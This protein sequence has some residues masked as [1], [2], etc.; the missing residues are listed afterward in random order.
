M[1]SY[2]WYSAA[3][4]TDAGTKIDGATSASY[5]IK[6]V[7]E[8]KTY[9][10]VVTNTK[11]GVSKS[12][13]SG[14]ITITMTE[15]A[16]EV[17]AQ[18]PVIE[19]DL[20]EKQLLATGASCTLTVTATSSDSGTL[21]Y[22]WYSAENATD[23]GTAIADAT[24]ESYT[25]ASFDGTTCYYY[26][27]ITNTVGAKK[28]KKESRRTVVVLDGTITVTLDIETI[29]Y[30]EFSEGIKEVKFRDRTAENKKITVSRGTTLAEIIKENDC[31]PIIKGEYTEEDSSVIEY[32][33]CGTFYNKQF[34]TEYEFDEFLSEEE[35]ENA[36]E[37]LFYTPLDSDC[38]FYAYTE[39][40]RDIEIYEK[41]DL[42]A[43]S[44]NTVPFY[45]GDSKSA[46][47]RMS[48]D[49]WRCYYEAAD[50]SDAVTV[51]PGSFVELK[52]TV[53]M[54]DE[55]KAVKVEVPA[56]GL[57]AFEVASEAMLTGILPN[58]NMKFKLVPAQWDK[59]EDL[60]FVGGATSWDFSYL[61]PFNADDEL[62]F[63]AASAEG[64]F[65]VSTYKWGMRFTNNSDVLSPGQSVPLTL[66]G[67]ADEGK[68][69]NAKFS[70]LVLG[71]KYTVQLKRDNS[72]MPVEISLVQKTWDETKKLYFMSA[73]TNW[74][75]TED[76]LFKD[77]NTYTFIANAEVV[78]FKICINDWNSEFLGNADFKDGL[79]PLSAAEGAGSSNG[80]IS[81]LVPGATYTVIL[82]RT[83]EGYPDY[84]FIKIKDAPELS[85]SDVKIVGMLD[86]SDATVKEFPLTISGSEGYC[87]F[88]WTR[89]AYPFSIKGEAV[90]YSIDSI[91]ALKNTE[92]LVY[93]SLKAGNGNTS[94][95]GLPVVTPETGYKWRISVQMTGQNQIEV[96]VQALDEIPDTAFDVIDSQFY[97]DKLAYIC[98]NFGIYPL[99]WRESSEE[100]GIYLGTVRIP[101]GAKNTWGADF[102]NVLEFGITADTNWN[103][104]WTYATADTPGTYVSCVKNVNDNN[105]IPNA[106][107]ADGNIVITVKSMADEILFM[108]T[109]E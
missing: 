7:E 12:K 21:S 53:C 31:I 75:L 38:T 71:A 109:V 86:D 80:A 1:L 70:G 9:Y 16:E 24:N 54:K 43:W 108:Y 42:V 10:V 74:N 32:Y 93:T 72:G 51:T 88:T 40:G 28:A 96:A 68:D 87:D 11:D 107:P 44:Q 57:Y 55:K 85:I 25:I 94:I 76:A 3:D 105:R 102:E 34:N 69:E 98:S 33:M 65:K 89:M 91:S 106:T 52:P 73:I 58:G 101:N 6:N 23:A 41:E 22:Q 20:P 60:Y 61:E 4:K 103:N 78:E 46:W 84:L 99:T 67:V 79:V 2:Q 27:V 45:V 50:G 90:S 13:I 83:V 19:E 64:E 35:N 18:E 17:T 62:T 30:N 56:P 48:Y 104:K 36:I 15:N 77:D 82:I 81:G 100:E 63:V 66:C 5:T 39:L 29:P 59:Y 37:T 47:V 14:K 8:T 49:N 26:V 95:S 92:S 97:T